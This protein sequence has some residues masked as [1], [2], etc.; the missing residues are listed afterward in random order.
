MDFQVPVVVNEAHLTKLVHEMTDARPGG[1]D[2]LR[3]GL[4]ADLCDD[5][6]RPSFLAE[7]GQQEKDPGKAF[8]G[9]IEQ[10]ID[11]IGLDPRIARED[12]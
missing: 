3:Q 12:M 8:L 11:K 4:L 2:H 7:V 1:A 10:L 9:R 6:L 5:G